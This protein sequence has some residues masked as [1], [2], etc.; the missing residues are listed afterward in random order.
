MRCL[1]R[2]IPRVKTHAVRV[3]QHS[4]ATAAAT[5]WVPRRW[6]VEWRWW[7]YEPF[8]RAVPRP[9][10][11]EGQRYAPLRRS[12]AGAEPTPRMGN[13]GEITCEAE[14][15]S[16]VVCAYLQFPLKHTPFR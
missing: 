7:R 14:A 1:E 3:C 15:P 13:A 10:L 16:G 12:R 11:T 4:Q 2:V 8:G 5:F 9:K 6:S